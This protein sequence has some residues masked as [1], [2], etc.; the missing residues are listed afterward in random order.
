MPCIIKVRISGIRN[1]NAFEKYEIDSFKY[2]EV[3][4]Q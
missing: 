4:K 3:V 2:L 1:I